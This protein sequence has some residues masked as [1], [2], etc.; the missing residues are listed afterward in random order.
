M[1]ACVLIAA[2]S[3]LARR[4]ADG[5]SGRFPL[6]CCIDSRRAEA[7]IATAHFQAIVVADGFLPAALD[8]TN[9]PVIAVGADV[10]VAD[11]A[12]RLVAAVEQHRSL[13]REAG[14][15]LLVLTR[16]DYDSYIELVRFRETRR[17]L[18]G[19]MHRHR[20][21]VT[22]AARG[23]GIV[24]ESLHRLLRRHGVDADMFRDN[25]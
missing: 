21:S 13:D 17:Y 7:L 24:R 25:A 16:L 19:L 3:L 5:L 11:V 6:M 23:A 12:T 18:L 20:G 9:A 2:P 4:L 10:D 1:R 22:D 14:A 8:A 15:E